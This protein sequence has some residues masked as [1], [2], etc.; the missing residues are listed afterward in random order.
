MVTI[1]AVKS[2]DTLHTIHAELTGLGNEQRTAALGIA[3]I[4]LRVLLD[5]NKWIDAESGIGI[6]VEIMLAGLHTAFSR[7][8]DHFDHI[9]IDEFASTEPA[10]EGP[11]L[12]LDL[13]EA[14]DRRFELAATLLYLV[15]ELDLL[16]L[17]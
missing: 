10:G 5:V 8:L 12:T 11:G 9:V 2:G 14:V 16:G 3:R 15:T 4:Q 1:N 17:R 6:G 7:L 13:S